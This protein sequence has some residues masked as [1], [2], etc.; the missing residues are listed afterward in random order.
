MG[1]FGGSPVGVVADKGAQHGDH[2]GLVTR[3]VLHDAL[4]CVD[5]AQPN[6]DGRGAE[7]TDGG[8]VAVSDLSLFGNLQLVVCGCN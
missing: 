4:Q 2:S 8:V 1:G 3:R 7:V 5:A 6:V